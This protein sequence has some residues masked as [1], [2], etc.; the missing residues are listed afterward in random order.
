MKNDLICDM[1]SKALVVTGITNRR[2][3]G[4]LGPEPLDVQVEGGS[5]HYTDPT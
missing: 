2:V 1:R 4:V 5:S 3:T